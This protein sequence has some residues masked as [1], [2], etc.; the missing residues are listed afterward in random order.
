MLPLFV[1]ELHY[2]PGQRWQCYFD[3][4]W[5]PHPWDIFTMYTAT[6]S[7]VTATVVFGI[8][9]DYFVIYASSRKAYPVIVSWQGGEVKCGDYEVGT[10]AAQ[11]YKHGL[12]CIIAIDPFETL[13]FKVKP[14]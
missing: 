7:H 10:A 9:V 12:C 8:G 11:V 6:V 4:V 14:V 3:R 5:V 2:D 13:V 1:V